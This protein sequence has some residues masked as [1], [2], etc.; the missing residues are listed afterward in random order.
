[1]E[2]IQYETNP[3]LQSRLSQKNDLPKIIQWIIR[4]S[5]GR[6]NNE[7]TATYVLLGFVVVIVLIAVAYPIFFG[8]PHRQIPPDA[9]IHVPIR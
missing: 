5:G 3:Q 1:M 7:K 4:Y 9:N 8:P 2:D 6:I